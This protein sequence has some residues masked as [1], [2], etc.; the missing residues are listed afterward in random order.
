[1]KEW[2]RMPSYWIR[3]EDQLPLAKLKWSGPDK[4]DQIAG[5]MLYVVLTHHANTEVTKDL[6]EPGLCALTY[7]QLSDITGLSRKKVAGGLRV[8]RGL[9]LISEI[10]TG[11]NNVYQIENYG[12]HAGW[13]KL[14][15]RGLYSRDQQTLHAFHKFKLRSKNELN[16]LKIYLLII[17]Q[18]TNTTNYAVISYDR[19]STY[20]G[21]ARNEIRAAIS[22]LVNLGLVHVDVGSSNLNNYS[23]MNLYRPSY[24]EA[25]KHRGT[26]AKATL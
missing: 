25:Y 24:L 26:T 13:A 2:A 17:A 19:I 20:T 5:L 9:N 10:S 6:S 15:A 21:I 3:D 11:R 8:L 12:S 22:L 7:T 23:V 14:P 16:A 1:M 18:R 4:T